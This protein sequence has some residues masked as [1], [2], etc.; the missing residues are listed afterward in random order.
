MTETLSPPR[1]TRLTISTEAIVA[2]RRAVAAKCAA[3]VEVAGVV[4]ADGYGTGGPQAAVA[5]AADGARTFF[6]AHVGEG[7]DV[8]AALTAAGWTQARIFVLNGLLPGTEETLAAH[9]LAPVLGSLPEI[10]DWAA[11]GRDQDL[12]LPCAIHVDT[13]MNRHGLSLEEARALAARPDLVAASG[14]D[15]V[16]SHLACADEPKHP[17]NALQLARFK[18]IRGLFPDI[19]ASLANSAGV[20][21]GPEY[22]FDLVRPGIAL[23]GGAIVSG[24]PSPMRPVVG[25][26][27]TILQVR[28]VP[29]GESV[30][31][32]A[33]QTVRRTSRLA[34]LSVGY[35]DGFHR[36]A[37]GA[38]SAPGGS[39]H[40][41][42]HR[43]PIVGR[44]S[45]DLLMVDVT[46]V[47]GAA[48]GDRVEL[49]GPHVSLQEVAKAMGT[50]DYE[51]LTSLGRRYQRV[52]V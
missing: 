29:H 45:M 17:L 15:L 28:D 24:Q 13:G 18:S 1:P 33:R 6:V 26:E 25:L 51:V 23:Y 43:V 50:I 20:F 21:L 30:G 48:R 41:A 39:G 12:P 47:P 4:K 40:L 10:E 52:R 34:V 14:A 35:A 37:S 38:D 3:S 22:H 2:N 16:M 31:Y 19:S 7:I 42:G 8:R 27:A 9:G 44:I 46:D 49:I 32:G 11:F 5:M 36:T